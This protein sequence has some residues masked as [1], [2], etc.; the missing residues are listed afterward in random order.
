MTLDTILSEMEQRAAQATAGP[1]I[2]ENRE[3]LS[4]GN[5]KRFICRLP[6][7]EGVSQDEGPFIAAA[8]ED[9]PRLCALARAQDAAL[10]VC[11]TALETLK[12]YPIARGYPDGPCLDKADHGEVIA[13]LAAA[14]LDAAGILGPQ[15]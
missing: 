10:Q 11:V 5:I 2:V 8:R 1:W 3:I 14:K 15:V 9:L 12:G 13:A 7:D 6:F 4:D